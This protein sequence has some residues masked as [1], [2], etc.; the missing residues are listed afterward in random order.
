MWLMLKHKHTDTI[1]LVC[2][3]PTDLVASVGP[4]SELIVVLQQVDKIR[5]LHALIRSL[6]GPSQGSSV[7]SRD[8]KHKLRNLSLAQWPNYKIYRL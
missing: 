1:S 8:L 3:I 6:V 2:L 4:Y 5:A 7:P